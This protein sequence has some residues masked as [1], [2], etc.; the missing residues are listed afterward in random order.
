MFQN[1][2]CKWCG[3]YSGRWDEE[4]EGFEGKVLFSRYLFLNRSFLKVGLSCIQTLYNQSIS[5]LFMLRLLSTKSQIHVQMHFSAV[6]S[7]S[8]ATAF[9]EIVRNIR[10]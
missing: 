6:I 4:M 2:K 1:S 10:N 3:A 9:A 5:G 7:L 8:S